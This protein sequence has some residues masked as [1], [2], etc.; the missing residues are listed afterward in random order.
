MD[1]WASYTSQ[2]YSCAYF[3]A[4]IVLTGAEWLA[5]RREASNAL[6]LR[7]FTNFSLTILGSMLT[8]LLFP[9]AAL[10][11]AEVCHGRGWGVLN[12]ASLSGW[13]ALVLT[14]V[15]L[16]LTNYAQHVALHRVPALW[17]VHRTHHTDHEYDF[18]IGVRFH[19]LEHL[20]SMTVLFAAIAA[21]GAPP[22]A[23]FAS[24]VISLVHS[25]VEHANV[26]IPVRLDRVLRFVLVT[27]DMHRV[28]HSREVAEGE[29]NFS[30]TFSWWDRLFGTYVDQPRAGH[31]G[32]AF[33]VASF[34]ER[35]HLTLPWS[36][37]NPFLSAGPS[38]P[39]E[40]DVA[41]GFRP[42]AAQGFTPA[43]SGAPEQG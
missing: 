39:R 15:A 14:V 33:G 36:L 11:W 41:Q 28:H 5:P 13:A 40:P 35:K 27:P 43:K 7:W 2:V 3:G 32:I 16:D 20:F 30:N 42:D 9:M 37:A 24:Q 10:G 4:I 12:T 29:S 21:L 31:D 26:R 25:F 8:R 23:V 1:N 38:S 19:P 17:R 6:V 18:T 22:W 34:E